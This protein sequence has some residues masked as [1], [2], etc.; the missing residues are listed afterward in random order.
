MAERTGRHRRGARRRRREPR[1]RTARRRRALASARP[2]NCS[3]RPPC[4]SAGRPAITAHALARLG[5]PVS[6]LAA[7]GADVFGVG[8][9]RRARRPGC[10]HRP[11]A[12]AHGRA[13][14][15]DGRALARRRPRDPD[16]PGRDPDAHR[17]RGARRASSARRTSGTSTSPRCT[18][19]RTWREL[20][21]PCSHDARAAG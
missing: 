18:C 16:L 10:R 8:A 14:R 13:D 19:S 9:A 12:R 21:L 17:R 3:T 15:R 2:S 11:A 5:R 7:I 20:C 4:S 1:S 6:L